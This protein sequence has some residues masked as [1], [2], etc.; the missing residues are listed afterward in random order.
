MRATKQRCNQCGARNK[1][2][3]NC[4]I[5]GQLLPEEHVEGP[6]FIDLVEEELKSWYAMSGKPVTVLSPLHAGLAVG[7]QDRA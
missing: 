1:A 6:L 3:V 7:R 2:V 5:C 4:R